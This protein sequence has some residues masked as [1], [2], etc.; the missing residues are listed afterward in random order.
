MAW[1]SST[2][3]SIATVLSTR[4]CI[5]GYLWVKQIVG[6]PIIWDVMTDGLYIGKTVFILRQDPGNTTV[7]WFAYPIPILHVV[8]RL[9]DL[10]SP[11]V[12]ALKLQWLIT[13][14]P[15]FLLLRK[16]LSF[17]FGRCHCVTVNFEKGTIRL[18]EIDLSTPTTEQQKNIWP[19]SW[20]ACV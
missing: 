8:S 2:R 12:G 10:E 6:L 16:Y 15:I 5:S 1:C 11:G 3:A 9:W 4:P 18:G 17:M 7:L 20:C 14:V 13:S 19:S